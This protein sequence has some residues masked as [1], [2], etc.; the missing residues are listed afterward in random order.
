MLHLLKGYPGN[1]ADIGA[2]NGIGMPSSN[3]NRVHCIHFRTTTLGQSMNLSLT[4][5][6]SYRLNRRSDWV[7]QGG[8][9]MQDNYNF[10]T[11]CVQGWQQNF[12]HTGTRAVTPNV[13]RLWPQRD[14][15][16]S[17]LLDAGVLMALMREKEMGS[18]FTIFPKINVNSRI[19][20]K[21]EKQPADRFD[22]Q[23]LEKAIAFKQQQR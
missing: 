4:P 1:L 14:Q 20:E 16:C 11:G 13:V 17:P 7:P 9:Q 6:H 3:S 2:A 22:H 23:C 5:Y 21:E 15:A 10:K 12:L 19:K 8:N 18:H